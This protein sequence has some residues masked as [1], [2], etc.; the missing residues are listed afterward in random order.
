MRGGAVASVDTTEEDRII[1]EALQNIRNVEP[2]LSVLNNKVSSGVVLVPMEESRL[3]ELNIE[4]EFEQKRITQAET[5]KKV[6]Q[7]E[8]NI[9]KVRKM[10]VNERDGQDRPDKLIKAHELLIRLINE[11]PV[12]RG[13]DMVGQEREELI[14]LESEVAR[15]Q[16]KKTRQAEITAEID[17]KEALIRKFETFKQSAADEFNKEKID[18]NIAKLQGQIEAL[19]QQYAGL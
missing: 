8:H 19:R 17:Q 5:Q 12:V 3:R 11:L 10:I 1:Q 6:K 14:S 7:K 18:S 9:E 15:L 2:E 16:I 13:T 4:L